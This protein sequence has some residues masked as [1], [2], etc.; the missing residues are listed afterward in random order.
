M[1]IVD[2]NDRPVGNGGQGRILI[3]TFNNRLMPLIRYDLGDTGKWINGAGDCA[4]GLDTPRLFFEGRLLD[5]V[6]FSD[7]RKFSAV[8]LLRKI[9]NKFTNIIA[10]QQIIQESLD[11]VVLKFV[12]GPAYRPFHDEILRSYIH[13][14][15]YG[16]L[17]ISI[18]IVKVPSLNN[19]RN[20]KHIIFESHIKA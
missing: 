10:K 15:F 18:E 11:K 20:G 8:N 7:G 17:E 16:F 6:R 3:T 9:D 4:C 2:D 1:E 19:I 12:P 13:N 5:Y 14:V